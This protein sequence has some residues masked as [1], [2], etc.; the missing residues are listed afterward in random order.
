MFILIGV[1]EPQTVSD[2]ISVARCCDW[3]GFGGLYIGFRF[4]TDYILSRLG[5]TPAW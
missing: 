2:K 5:Q 3:L 4:V 1:V